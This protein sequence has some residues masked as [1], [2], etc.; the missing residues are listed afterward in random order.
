MYSKYEKLRKKKKVNNRTV[1]R[2]TG[3]APSVIY[4][5]KAG[6]S[7]PKVDKLQKIATYFGV[8]IEDLL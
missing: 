8:R 4:D 5:W 1:A 7:N 3:I 6:R 2:E